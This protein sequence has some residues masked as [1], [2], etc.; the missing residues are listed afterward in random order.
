MLQFIKPG[1]QVTDRVKA[2]V[3]TRQGGASQP[4]YDSLNLAM[5]VGDDPELVKSNRELLVKK[6][7]LPNEPNWLEQVHGTEVFNAGQKI[8]RLADNCADAAFSNNAGEVCVVLTAD[9]LPV[10]LASEDGSEVA[11]AHAGWK[12]L[13]AGVIENTVKEF[14][15]RPD[16]IH[17]WLG[18]A[19]GPEAFDVGDEVRQAFFEEAALKDN[20]KFQ[21]E[22]ESI[23]ASFLPGLPGVASDASHSSSSLHA[24]S[25]PRMRGS[26]GKWFANIYKLAQIRLNRVGVSRITG[27]AFCTYRQPEIFYSY[28]R[29]GKTGRMASLI[30]LE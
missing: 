12:G 20:G 8:D 30:W 9:C 5:H 4:P 14:K 16:K 3:T 22:T 19:I 24:L 21:A 25:S 18:P 27:G 6:L 11:V 23:K 1:W 7:K 13:L 29:D 17:A 26:R 2:F 10:F 15:S 28:R